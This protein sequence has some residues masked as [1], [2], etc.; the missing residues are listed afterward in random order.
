MDYYGEES[1]NYEIYKAKMLNEDA[2]KQSL[3]TIN[4]Q[5]FK[6]L[7]QPKKKIQYFSYKNFH[8]HV[9]NDITMEHM[10]A[11][12]PGITFNNEAYQ[13]YER[14]NYFESLEK[15]KKAIEIKLKAYGENSIHICISLSGLADC[16]LK[17]GDLENATKEAQ[18][19]LRISECIKRPDQ[20]KIA[21]EI[22][23]DIEK[24]AKSKSKSKK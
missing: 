23:V 5:K 14:G 12:G 17:L 21:K 4:M 11:L 18:R 24:A 15:Y 10:L 3:N 1:F 16:Y 13:A 8:A 7:N 6:Q 9:Q 2:F 19:M 20:I 22:L